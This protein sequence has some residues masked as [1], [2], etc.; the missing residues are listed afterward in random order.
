MAL[1]SEKLPKINVSRN[2]YSLSRTRR[3]M[4]KSYG[5]TDIKKKWELL[6]NLFK[7]KQPD[8]IIEEFNTPPPT[9]RNEEPKAKSPVIVHQPS[10]HVFLPIHLNLNITGEMKP[11]EFKNHIFSK[12]AVKRKKLSVTEIDDFG[13]Q[14]NFY[15]SGRRTSSLDAP[16]ERRNSV[17]TPIEILKNEDR[18]D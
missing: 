13:V 15:S 10:N 7:N 3:N 6:S 4:S 5:V 17:T 8:C 16:Q 9:S 2:D 1:R 12:L 14:G 11:I 18:S